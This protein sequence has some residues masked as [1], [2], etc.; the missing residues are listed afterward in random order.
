MARNLLAAVP[1]ESEYPDLSANGLRTRLLANTPAIDLRDVLSLCWALGIPVLH[2]KIFPLAAKRMCAMAVR[3]QDRYAILLAKE[4]SYPAQ[5]AFY[6]AHE[7]GHIALGHL[8]TRPAVV[9]IEDP[10]SSQRSVDAEE[11]SADRYALELLTGQPEPRVVTEAR[12][13]SASALAR[14]VVEAGPELG[15]DP[16]TLALC[17]GHSTGR[18]RKAFG[19]LKVIYGRRASVSRYVNH[20]AFSQLAPESL[21]D[22]AE[23]YLRGATGG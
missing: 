14:A 20:V 17:F 3:V 11:Q 7:L 2:L 23:E 22:E 1:R 5:I 15:I 4:S 9:D 6:V 8:V 21:S 18:W 19:A 10:L 13:Y 16:A 12:S